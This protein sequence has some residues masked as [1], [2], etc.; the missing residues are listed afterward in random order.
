MMPRQRVYYDYVNGELIPY[1][2]VLTFKPNQIEWDTS[3]IYFN[4][5]APFEYFSRDNFDD[6]ILSISILMSDIVTNKDKPNILGIQLK[7]I[8]ENIL[9]YD[10]DPNLCR[11]FILQVPDIQEVL[12]LLPNKRNFFVIK[13]QQHF[14]N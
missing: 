11:Q 12:N 9:K 10:V 6:S 7:R 4:I 3:I 2:Y 13:E 8:K 1:W 14:T 5:I